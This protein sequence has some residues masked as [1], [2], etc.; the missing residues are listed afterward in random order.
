MQETPPME[1]LLSIKETAARCGISPRQVYKLIA[2]GRFGPELVHI[3][4]SVRIRESELDAWLQ[5][6]CPP[7]E[8][9]EA[10]RAAGA[11][12]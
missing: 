8:R 5:A 11:D 9:F 3:A 10:L 4:R 7:R 6:S 1:R 12:R 2:S